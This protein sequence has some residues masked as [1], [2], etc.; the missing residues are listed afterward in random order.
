[1]R[2][3][4]SLSLNSVRIKKLQR[5]LAIIEEGYSRF[6]GANSH[7]WEGAEMKI[8]QRKANL[9]RQQ[10]FDLTGDYYGNSKT[11]LSKPSDRLL[12]AHY[13][14][15][16]DI[17]KSVLDWNNSNAPL[18]TSDATDAIRW[19]RVIGTLDD[20]RF[21]SGTITIYRATDQ[22]D[23]IRPGDWVT[24]NYDYAYDHLRRY[25]RGKGSIIEMHVD[26]RNVLIS[27]TGNYD[28][29]I[30]APL[31]YSENLKARKR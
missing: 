17:P 14:K 10:L 12:Q 25:L 28:E 27:P 8:E 29:A 20:D 21:P 16:E 30:Y 23:E 5:E 9:I 11:K 3:E 6:R 13:A 18:L 7:L 31:K 24:T 26:G 22:G 2:I 19:M 1:M 4:I 15:P